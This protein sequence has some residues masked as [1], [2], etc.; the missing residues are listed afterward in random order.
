[1]TVTVRKPR[2]IVLDILGTASKSGFLEQILFPYL[3]INLE[4]YITNH[5]K[6]KDFIRIYNKILLQ[7]ADFH[8]SEPST[9]VVLAHENTSAKQSL[10]TFITFVTE[11]GINCPPVTQLRFMVWFEGY[12]QNKLKTP[13]YS[14]VPN[15]MR[16]WFSQG[17]KFYVFSNTW[18]AAQKAL[19][20]NTN[21]GDLT[22]LISGHY[23]NDF[24]T[25]TESDSWRRLCNE[26]RESPND[27]L[28]LTKSPIEA[29]AASDAG[30]SVVLVLTHRH[31]V[32]AVSHEDRR[33]FPH[34]RTLVELGWQE[35]QTAPLE[36]AQ[37]SAT[38]TETTAGTGTS[39]AT[40]QSDSGFS[41]RGPPSASQTQASASTVATSSTASSRQASRSRSN[42]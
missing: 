42:K 32:K 28:F 3:K 27:V 14:D 1:M 6:D 17:I 20:K 10:M 34:V 9:P 15:Q 18:V 41:T 29:R 30:L 37:P 23:D 19:L 8:K 22:N 4:N 5:W 39:V 11:N 7:S 24:G 16:V 13:I 25:M 26:I 33:R 31:N 35:G 21:H 12:Q 40:K 38:A 36:I 2:A